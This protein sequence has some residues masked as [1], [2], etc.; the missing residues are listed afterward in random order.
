MLRTESFITNCPL[1]PLFVPLFWFWTVWLKRRILAYWWGFSLVMS[2]PTE[3]T[4]LNSHSLF[5]R[6]AMLCSLMHSKELQSFFFI[7]IT[8]VDANDVL[9]L[10]LQNLLQSMKYCMIFIPST[11]NIH[12]FHT[13]LGIQWISSI[14]VS[15]RRL[16]SAHFI[17]TWVWIYFDFD[18]N[19]VS[20]IKTLQ[21]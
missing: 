18:N 20:L 4:Q 1:P 17:R 6:L 12:Q 8:H 16:T 19:F 10:V 11:Y 7:D 3:H 5:S 2:A 14:T 13:M 21:T 15:L 9:C